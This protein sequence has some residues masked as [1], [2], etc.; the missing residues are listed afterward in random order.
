[1]AKDSLANIR[2]ASD[3]A[4][5]ASAVNMGWS[6]ASDSATQRN[7][8]GMAEL[9]LIAE[10]ISLNSVGKIAEDAQRLLAY[11][12]ASVQAPHEAITSFFDPRRW[13]GRNEAYKKCPDCAEK[14]AREARVCRYCGYRYPV[15]IG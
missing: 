8:E 4:D 6:L 7:A 13:F 10:E 9:G 15:D 2:I 3:R 12:A 5:Y 14:I 1:M 11:C